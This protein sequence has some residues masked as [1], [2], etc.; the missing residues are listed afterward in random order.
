MS[1]NLR[2]AVVGAGVIGRLHARAIA[3]AEGAELAAVVDVDEER[4]KEVGGEHGVSSYRSLRDLVDSGGVDAITIGVPSG[5]HA[6][7]GMEAAGFGLHVLCEKPIDVSLQAAD[8]LI[9][10]CESNSVKLAC[11]SQ[12]RFEP[13]I[14]G[15]YEAV[16]NGGRGE[17][18]AAYTDDGRVVGLATA[19]LTDGGSCKV[20]GFAHK[21]HMGAWPDLMRAATKWATDRAGGAHAVVCV[22]DEEKQAAFEA[23]DFK[24]GAP[25]KPFVLGD[26]EVGSVRMQ[27]G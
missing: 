10:A 18:F 26:R 3:E 25:A 8:A 2:I 20:D 4:A 15:T 1:A 17:W 7:V 21:R 9:A 5:S 22:E 11:V 24:L 13:D 19:R 27:L 23:L 14:A 6:A 16:R 12:S